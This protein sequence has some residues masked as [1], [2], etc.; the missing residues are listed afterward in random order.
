MTGLHRTAVALVVGLAGACTPT[1][2]SPTVPASGETPRSTPVTSFAPPTSTPIPSPNATPVQ[3]VFGSDWHAVDFGQDDAD[4]RAAA[5]G[6]AGAVIVGATCEGSDE[7]QECTASAWHQGA[8]GKWRKS[9]VGDAAGATMYEVVHTDRFVALG[10]RI[11]QG[12]RVVRALIWSSSDGAEWRLTG[13]A[14][15]GD[16]SGEGPICGHAA[17][18]AATTTGLVILGDV[19]A[20]GDA[21]FFGALASTDGRHWTRIEPS[22]FDGDTDAYISAAMPWRDGVVALVG[23]GSR[24]LTAWRTTDG[25]AW[26]GFGAFGEGVQSIGALAEHGDQLIAAEGEFAGPEGSRTTLWTFGDGEQFERTGVFDGVILASLADA[27][28]MGIVAVGHD[29]GRP[30]VFASLDGRSWH[31]TAPGLPQTDCAPTWL[32]GGPSTALYVGDCGMVWS[33]SRP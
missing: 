4:P 12:G 15:I 20:A 33:A 9:S 32:A 23:G 14:E 5:Y 18:L 13:S 11:E 26:A 8:D 27:G 2:P 17:R 25:V 28:P 30:Q 10:T 29:E 6:E 21:G 3:G 24:P 19:Y 31:R 7:A 22:T 16:C 1:V